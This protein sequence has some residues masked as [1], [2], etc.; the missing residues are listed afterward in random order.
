[1]VAP[2]SQVTVQLMIEMT[3]NVSFV[4]DFIVHSDMEAMIGGLI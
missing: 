4:N 1:M 2:Q 3:Q